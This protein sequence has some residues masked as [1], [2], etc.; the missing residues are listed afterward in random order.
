MDM[1]AF[2]DDLEER[3]S[4]IRGIAATDA[5]EFCAH[6]CKPLPKGGKEHRRA[7]GHDHCEVCADLFHTVLMRRY[8]VCLQLHFEIKRGTFK[9]IHPDNDYFFF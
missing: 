4:R 9:H 7:R 8:F 6:C 3:A 2:I 1:K 5:S